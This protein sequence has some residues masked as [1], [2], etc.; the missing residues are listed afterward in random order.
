MGR[1][2]RFIRDRENR[3]DQVVKRKKMEKIVLDFDKDMKSFCLKEWAEIGWDKFEE[4]EIYEDND[5][6]DEDVYEY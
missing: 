2:T 1:L 4:Y 6:N 3:K 5:D